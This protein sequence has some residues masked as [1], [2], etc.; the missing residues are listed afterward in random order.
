MCS[1]FLC[2]SSTRKSARKSKHGVLS[3]CET[4]RK[5]L[6]LNADFG[7]PLVGFPGLKKMRI[8]LPGLNMGKSGGYR[9]IYRAEMVDEIWH[10]VFLAIFFKGDLEDLP[11]A[12]YKLLHQKSEDIISDTLSHEW[13]EEFE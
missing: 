1:R 7:E 13:V 5:V 2:S 3:R 8:A 11:K 10:I 4:I 12:Q 9:L 6:T